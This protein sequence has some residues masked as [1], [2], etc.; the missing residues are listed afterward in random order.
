M[1]AVWSFWSRP[2]L[3]SRKSQWNTPLHHFLAWGISLRAARRHYPDTALITDRAGKRLLVDGLG[4]SFTEVSTELEMLREID[5][6]W[7]ALGKLVAYSIQDRPFIHIDTDV[8]LWKRLPREVTDA[9][10]FAQCPEFHSNDS[11]PSLRQIE[12]AFAESRNRLPVEWEWARSRNQE[13]FREENCGIVGG[14]NVEFFRHYA[15]TATDLI[16]APEN[17][18]A[19]SQLPEKASHNFTLEQF[20][21]AACIDFHRFHAGSPYRGIMV[22]HLF[23]GVAEACDLNRAA[24]VGYT[25][26]WGGTKAHPAVGK[27]L[28]ERVRR[29]DPAYLHRCQQVL[30]RPIA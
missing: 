20:F 16:L 24:R 3:A 6:G 15:R 23:P 17:L 18:C 13:S 4:L 14:T 27:R 5:P 1:R 29:E 7:W 11:K 10:V 12:C 21:L 25:H 22:S 8:F 28:E 26:L 9:P 2:F 19:W 30:A